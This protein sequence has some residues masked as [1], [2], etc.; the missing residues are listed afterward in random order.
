MADVPGDQVGVRL[1]HVA[2]HTPQASGHFRLK[3]V[4]AVP[5]TSLCAA[6]ADSKPRPTMALDLIDRGRKFD[7]FL[8]AA[9]M[10]LVR[11]DRLDPL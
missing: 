11:A 9:P 4:Q 3:G 5:Q 2:T 6:G 10:D 7:A 1:P 8:L